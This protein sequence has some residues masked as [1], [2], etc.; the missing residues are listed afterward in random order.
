MSPPKS[1]CHS[2]GASSPFNPIYDVASTEYRDRLCETFA[3]TPFGSGVRELV[4]DIP[5]VSNEA[6][7]ANEAA[8]TPF[9][10]DS[11]VDVNPARM[12]CNDEDECDSVTVLSD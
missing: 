7:V 11:S 6:E 1:V 10:P 8:Y 5:S 4:W 3:V 2:S 12:L 9:S